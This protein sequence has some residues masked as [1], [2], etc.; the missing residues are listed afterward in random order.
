MKINNIFTQNLNFQ[1]NI[2]KNNTFNKSANFSKP[3]AN[4]LSGLSKD[5]FCPAFKGGAADIEKFSSLLDE[6]IT[7]NNQF[8]NIRELN[9]LMNKVFKF[10]TKT[11]E[12]FISNGN[13][14]KV[15]TIDSKYVLR[16]PKELTDRPSDTN[17]F[18]II[19]QTDLVKSLKTYY[20]SKLAQCVD[21]SI[22]VLKNADPDKNAICLGRPF[23]DSYNIA[24]SHNKHIKDTF[25]E[26]VKKLSDFPQVAYDNVASDMYS[27]ENSK[28][29]YFFDYMNPNNFMLLGDGVSSAGGTSGI[30]KIRVVDEIT[31]K[32]NFGRN[33]AISML[34]AFLTN[35][36]VSKSAYFDGHLVENRQ[37][38]FKKCFVSI[39]KYNLSLDGL[40]SDQVLQDAINLTKYKSL[41]QFLKKLINLRKECPDSSQRLG[42]V[43]DFLNNLQ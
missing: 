37:N 15:Y 10:I 20:G 40:G 32:S 4:N 17:D 25:D 35:E 23:T 39:E 38:I 18:T 33:D 8:A 34:R 30:Q 27:L 31:R 2:Q 1:Q 42:I 14:N 28:P 7:T 22:T 41:P 29:A 6:A 36:Q 19:K 9:D 11:P 5:T 16:T 13:S 21:G 26:S 43:K 24:L 3:I 12:Y